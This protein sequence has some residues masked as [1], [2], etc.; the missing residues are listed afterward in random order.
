VA[1]SP[2]VHEKARA[3][4]HSV[5]VAVALKGTATPTAAVAPA[6]AV[7]VSWHVVTVVTENVVGGLARDVRLS[8]PQ[9]V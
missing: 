6:V 8:T 2:N 5:A 9:A 7:Q 3:P 4:L 1:P